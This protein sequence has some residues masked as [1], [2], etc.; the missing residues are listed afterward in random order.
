MRRVPRG[1]HHHCCRPDEQQSIVL[2]RTIHGDK[3]TQSSLLPHRRRCH[4][5]GRLKRISTGQ[6]HNNNRTTSTTTTT[7]VA[8]TATVHLT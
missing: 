8:A 3:I 6:K 1:C 2:L 7:I 5:G 4:R